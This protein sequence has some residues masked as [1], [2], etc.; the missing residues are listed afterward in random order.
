MVGGRGSF[1]ADRSTRPGS[2]EFP[3]RWRS[4]D[5]RYDARDILEE[6][7]ALLA[8]AHRDRLKILQAGYKLDEPV[9][10]KAAKGGIRFRIRVRNGTDGHGVPTGFDAERLVYLE[11]TLADSAGHTVFQSGDLDP[12]GDVR[13]LHS[14]YVHNGELPLDK[15]LFSLQSRFVTRMVRGGEREQVIALN[16]SPDPLPFLRPSTSSTIL[17]GRPG[18]ARKHKKN[19]EPGGSVWAKYNVPGKALN[20]NGPYQL[21]IRMIAGMIPVNLIHEISGVGFDYGLSAREVADAV[22]KGHL[23]LWER[24]ATIDVR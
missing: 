6:N 19:I 16:F 23:V 4:A 18:G 10:D 21:K 9:I 7:L 11:V 24:E 8:E 22:V 13:D 2:H 20:G 3:E 12:N 15:Q 1:P 14:L 17:T 5:D